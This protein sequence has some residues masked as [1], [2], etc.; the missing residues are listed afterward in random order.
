MCFCGPI[1][2]KMDEVVSF[3]L[4]LCIGTRVVIIVGENVKYHSAV[5]YSD[6]R[7]SRKI[8]RV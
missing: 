2:R 3:Y 5:L 7:L 4:V 6:G 1:Y 8:P